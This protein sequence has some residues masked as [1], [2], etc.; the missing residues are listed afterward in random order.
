MHPDIPSGNEAEWLRCARDSYYFCTKYCR[1]I[2]P[3]TPD[4]PAKLFTS[5]EAMRF[6]LWQFRQSRSIGCKSR[7]MRF[8]NTIAVDALHRAIFSIGTAGLFLSKNAGAAGFGG[9]DQT[10]SEARGDFSGLLGRVDYMRANLPEWL[11]VPAT[12]SKK[13]GEDSLT[14]EITSNGGRVP[15]IIYARSSKVTSAESLGLNAVWSDEVGIQK[16]AQQRHNSVSPTLGGK[17]TLSYGGTPRERGFH[18][19]ACFGLTSSDQDIAG[20]IAYVTPP[21]SYWNDRFPKDKKKIAIWKHA[22]EVRPGIW[23]GEVK[24]W[25]VWFVHYS[26]DPDKRSRKW[27]DRQWEGYD[28]NRGGWLLHF[29][30]D[31]WAS[32]AD[33][34]ALVPSWSSQNIRDDCVYDPELGTVYR[35]LDP[36]GTGAC[37]VFAQLAGDEN[38]QLRIF[39]CYAPLNVGIET[40]RDEIIR[41]SVNYG[42]WFKNYGDRGGTF[43]SDMTRE[44]SLRCSFDAL[45][46]SFMGECERNR[47]PKTEALIEYKEI[48]SLNA[49]VLVDAKV[50]QRLEPSR[51]AL[52]GEPGLI[53][54]PL[55]AGLVLDALAGKLPKGPGGKR[56][57]DGRLEHPY[58]AVKIGISHLWPD[59]NAILSYVPRISIYTKPL[60]K[61][62]QWL[63][64][65]RERGMN[66]DAV[67]GGPKKIVTEAF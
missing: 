46:E 54:H 63:K 27:G 28:T 8:S 9:S 48:G 30:M 50:G 26:A 4:F 37:C 5:S 16:D 62:E 60:S 58:D 55:K 2:D 39:D 45:E 25:Y 12:P 43:K 1:S 67:A 38:Q 66:Q 11:R 21:Y 7:R 31:W 15:S 3:E 17:G 53:V 59:I 49:Q 22:K 65:V 32:E 56:K 19:R 52:S 34:G 41:R 47:V 20:H 24:G 61:H 14:F 51:N 35:F 57:R 10:G 40:F 64:F 13:S 6:W 33:E 23:L 44:K 18:Y 29:E 36:G 42:K